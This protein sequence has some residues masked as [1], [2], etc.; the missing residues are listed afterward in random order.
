MNEEK[1]LRITALFG[2]Y[3]GRLELKAGIINDDG[4]AG[5]AIW[6]DPA[7]RFGIITE[8]YSPGK[9]QSVTARIYG[10]AQVWSAVYFT[11][12]VDSI[13]KYNGR[14]TGFFGAGIFFDDDDL[15]YLLV[16]K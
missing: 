13:H 5:A 12:G 11:G 9:G 6:A 8:I 10:R 2:K 4:A 15:K 3:F 7:R 16:F 14:G 1:G